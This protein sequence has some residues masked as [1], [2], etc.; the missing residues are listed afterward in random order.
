[1]PLVPSTEMAQ[2]AAQS[3]AASRACCGPQGSCLTFPVKVNGMMAIEGSRTG[4]G[5]LT[6]ELLIL[7]H[8]AQRVTV[9]NGQHLAIQ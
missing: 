3:T 7:P 2:R 6:Q 9:K 4:R 8:V 5:C 1:M